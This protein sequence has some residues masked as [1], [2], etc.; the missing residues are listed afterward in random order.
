MGVTVRQ[1]SLSDSRPRH[2]HV[3]LT[4]ITARTSQG[5]FVVPILQKRAAE[6]EG[7]AGVHPDSPRAPDL[8]RSPAPAL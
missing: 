4:P 7:K 1:T 6:G 5:A 3:P 8:A 2:I